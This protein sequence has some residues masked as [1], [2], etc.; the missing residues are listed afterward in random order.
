ALGPGPV[1][2]LELRLPTGEPGAVGAQD[3]EAV[4]RKGGGHA[5]GLIIKRGWE[6]PRLGTQATSTL[7]A[8]E[9]LQHVTQGFIPGLGGVFAPFPG[10][11]PWA[12]CSGPSGAKRALFGSLGRPAGTQSSERL[13]SG[14]Q[15]GRKAGDRADR[16]LD[17]RASRPGDLHG[18][19]GGE[20]GGDPVPL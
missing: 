4:G 15:D 11:K 1:E 6:L 18:R 19:D 14:G 3:L 17:A 7:S 10:L 2:R 5:M 9:G 13:R 16:E 8:P 12:T 20:G